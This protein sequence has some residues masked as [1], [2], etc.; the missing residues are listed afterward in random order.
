[1]SQSPAVPLKPTGD[2]PRGLIFASAAYVMWGFL[3]LF[4]KALAHIPAPEVVAH[5]IIWSLPLAGLVL[6]VTG[7]FADIKAALVSPR[8]LAMAVLTATLIT[9]NWSIYVWAISADRALEAAL[10]YYINPLISVFLGSV[11]LK[12]KLQKSQIAAIALASVAVGVLAVDAGGLPWVSISLALTWAFYAFFRKTLPV[13]PN[14]G[15]F[16][17]VLLLSLP[18]L[19]YILYLES[20][21]QG[22]F[23]TDGGA[24]VSWLLFTG[25]VTAVP[26]IVYANGAKLLRLSTIGILQYI[27]PTMIFLTA[28]FVFHEPFGTAKMIAFPLIWLALIVYSSSMIANLRARRALAAVEAKAAK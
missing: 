26:L 10:G 11:L 18:A 27:A 16:L 22:H 3:P 7:R 13:G 19:G 2:T 5:R 12:E 20:S 6:L 8:T 1:M 21:G 9:L 28:V 4:M 23:L 25:V 14:Q 17:E 15:F 24:N